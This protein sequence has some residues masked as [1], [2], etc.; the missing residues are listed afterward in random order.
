[1]NAQVGRPSSGRVDSALR[2][3]ASKDLKAGTVVISDA[4]GAPPTA[5]IAE[6]LAQPENVPGPGQRVRVLP[7]GQM[8][9]VLTLHPSG[10][11]LV[12]RL[13]GDGEKKQLVVIPPSRLEVVQR[14]SAIM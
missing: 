11:K 1:M 8:G 2:C 13:D 9:T 10:T 7:E 3:I 4:P 12:V 14:K 5:A 6:A